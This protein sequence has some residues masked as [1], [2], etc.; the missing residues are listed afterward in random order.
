MDIA[1]SGL[2][3]TATHLRFDEKGFVHRQCGN[4]S[5]EL[6]PYDDEGRLEG[7]VVWKRASDGA[8]RTWSV[9]DAYSLEGDLLRV[10]DSARGTTVYETDGAH[11]LLSETTPQ[12]QQL[13]YTLDVSDNVISKPGLGHAEMTSGNRVAYTDTEVSSA[14]LDRS[15]RQ[16]LSLGRRTRKRKPL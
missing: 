15:L 4:G 12:G 11:R 5:N 10:V 3:G 6:L 13:F 1:P 2:D 9:R 16:H 7:R 8:M 14:L